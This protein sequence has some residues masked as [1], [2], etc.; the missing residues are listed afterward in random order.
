MSFVVWHHVSV[1]GKL[2]GWPHTSSTYSAPSCHFHSL[3]VCCSLRFQHAGK[4]CPNC[5]ILWQPTLVNT[6]RKGFEKERRL[7]L[8]NFCW[9][10]LTLWCVEHVSVESSNMDGLL[11]SLLSPWTCLPLSL[12]LSLSLLRLSLWSSW[13]C[14][15]FMTSPTNFAAPSLYPEHWVNVVHKHLSAKVHSW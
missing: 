1:Q 8:I 14:T 2:I 6:L 10:S 5:L 15:I 11:R 13:L 3:S 4:A 7:F 9:D 12:V